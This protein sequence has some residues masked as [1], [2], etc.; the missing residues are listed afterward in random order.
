M[1]PVLPRN[2][3]SKAYERAKEREIDRLDQL[4]AQLKRILDSILLPKKIG[5]GDIDAC[6]KNFKN[7]TKNLPT[8]QKIIGIKSMIAWIQEPLVPQTDMLCTFHK[9]LLAELPSEENNQV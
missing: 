8:S 6:I 5:Q 7:I 9:A 3:Q 2:Y 4:L 1:I